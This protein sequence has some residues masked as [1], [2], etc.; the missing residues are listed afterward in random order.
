MTQNERILKYLKE[1]NGI[2]SL[3]ATLRLNC[4]RLAARIADLEK[5]GHKFRHER[6]KEGKSTFVRYYLEETNGK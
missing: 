6:V 2:T 1:N 5:M 3:E 4:T